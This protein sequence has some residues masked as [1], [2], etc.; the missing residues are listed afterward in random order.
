MVDACF[1]DRSGGTVAC[2]QFKSEHNLNYC[3]VESTKV[4]NLIS[5]PIAYYRQQQ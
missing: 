5:M 2:V 3:L 4:A 1:I